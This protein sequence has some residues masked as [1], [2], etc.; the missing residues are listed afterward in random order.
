MKSLVL[1]F[2]LAL[3]LSLTPGCKDA[4]S[5]ATATP[6]AAAPD[7]KDLVP[8]QAP[9]AKKHRI[10]LR[11]YKHAPGLYNPAKNCKNCHGKKLQGIGDTPSCYSCHGMRW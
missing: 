7:S 1:L 3:T 8:P 11:G 10:N 5:T 4:D 2:C 6:A 9:E